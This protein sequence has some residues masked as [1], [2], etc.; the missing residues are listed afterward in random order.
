MVVAQGHQAFRRGTGATPTAAAGSG[1]APQW[2]VLPPDKSGL[3]RYQ[4]HVFVAPG[5][6]QVPHN[7]VRDLL[8][9]ALQL[10]L[11]IRTA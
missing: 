7:R 3:L 11:P 6:G 9:A 8:R 4:T 1:H 10:L 2:P 5:I